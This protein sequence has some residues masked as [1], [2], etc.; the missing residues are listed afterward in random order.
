MS[1]GNASNHAAHI[2]TVAESYAQ[3]RAALRAYFSGRVGHAMDA[4]NLVHQVY[5]RVLR[6]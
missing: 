2:E 5:E 4:E 1:S 6:Y 3:Y